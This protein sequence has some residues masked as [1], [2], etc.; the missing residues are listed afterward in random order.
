VISSVATVV[1]VRLSRL[2][3]GV[4]PTDR[5]PSPLYKST[6]ARSI[7]FKFFPSNVNSQG[8]P[9]MLLDAKYMGL[10]QR[11]SVF[12]GPFSGAMKDTRPLAQ[13]MPFSPVKQRISK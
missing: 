9:L 6:R 11:A 1:P 4:N 12:E 13:V 7:S 10:L 5:L 8:F 2:R 3:Q